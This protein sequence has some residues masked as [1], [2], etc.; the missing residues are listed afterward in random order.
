M[1]H[2]ANKKRVKGPPLKE[3]DTVYLLRRNIKTKR[4]SDK[5]D[6]KRTGPFRITKKL[7][8]V[9]YELDLRSTRVHLQFYT[10]LLELA[11]KEV[12]VQSKLH[13]VLEN[14]YEV[15]TILNYRGTTLREEYLVK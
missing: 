10:L 7:S 12:L 4:P 9:T 13:V 5:L 2:Y 11:L 15:K 8:D 6:H 14:E 3:G 1:T